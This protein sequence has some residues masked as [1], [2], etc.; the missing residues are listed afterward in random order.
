MK[1][2]II[3][4]GLYSAIS[5]LVLFI[6]GQIIGKNLDYSTQEIFGY[7]SM[8]L[9]LLFVFF[10]IRHF[11]DQHNNGNLKFGKGLILG[12]LISL[13]AA[14][15][16]GII[17][18]IYIKYINP[19]FVT[20]YYNHSVEQLKATV[21]AELLESKL[22]EM[23]SQREMFTNPFISFLVMTFTVFLLGLIISLLSALILQRK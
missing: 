8:I 14:I 5:L 9:S 10:G 7:A 21:P 23:E 2:T 15:A 1:K 20:E 13:I 22:Q 3:R 12:L 18:I 4:Y 16:F 17:D 11:R 6:L 19:D